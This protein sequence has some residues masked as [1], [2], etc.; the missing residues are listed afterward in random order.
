[1]SRDTWQL[2]ASHRLRQHLMRAVILGKN[3]APDQTYELSKAGKVGPLSA[4]IAEIFQ[5]HAD[6]W[7]ADM[8]TAKDSDVD[9]DAN[10]AWLATM[11]EAELEVG[12]FLAGHT[13]AHGHAA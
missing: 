1:M 10:Q 13:L 3:F 8:R 11:R 6:L 9:V 12:R 5:R 4:Q 2:D 7:A